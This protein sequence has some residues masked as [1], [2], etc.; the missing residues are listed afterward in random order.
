MAV[1]PSVVIDERG[2]VAHARYLVAVV[3][4]GHD[5][6]LVVRVLT[7]PVVRLAEIIQDRPT[8]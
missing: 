5:A 6:G 4:P 1:V 8:P 7:Q 2:F 3:P